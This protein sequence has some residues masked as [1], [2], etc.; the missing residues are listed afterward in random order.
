MDWI[1]IVAIPAAAILC[2]F[3]I[4]FFSHRKQKA[5]DELI[6]YFA[7][8]LKVQ[9]SSPDLSRVVRKFKDEIEL[10]VSY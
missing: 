6:E 1:F 3:A 4:Q 7:D 10:K 2:G 9:N 5:E 8:K